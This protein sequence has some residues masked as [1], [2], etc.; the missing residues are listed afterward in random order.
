MI[1]FDDSSWKYT[2][3]ILMTVIF[4][5]CGIYTTLKIFKEK[6]K[7]N[8]LFNDLPK[9][10]NDDQNDLAL[11]KFLE[12]DNNNLNNNVVEQENN[13]L[14]NSNIIIETNI[15]DIVANEEKEEKSIH[16]I[17]VFEYVKNTNNEAL[18]NKD[19][20]DENP[21][22]LEEDSIIKKKDEVE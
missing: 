22:I 4:I 8:E 15:D 3:I 2:F 1:L 19:T 9:T 5:G 12:N 14:V 18:N 16:T 21:I 13:D 7:E 20:N 17:N 6:K 10:K 11:E